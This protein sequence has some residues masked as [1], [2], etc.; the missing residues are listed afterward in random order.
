MIRLVTGCSWITAE[1]LIAH[2]ASDT[3]LRARRDEWADAGVFDALADEALR[4][5]DRIVGLDLSET[6]VDGRST[7]RP[8]AARQ[9]PCCMGWKWSSDGT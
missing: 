9:K 6:A 1:R 2:R 3:T 8:A 7:R 5:Y 4:A